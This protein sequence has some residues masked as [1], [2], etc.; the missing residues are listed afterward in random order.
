MLPSHHKQKTPSSV[1]SGSTQETPTDCSEG[2]LSDDEDGLFAS[3][4]H[5]GLDSD[6]SSVEEHVTGN[7]KTF[8]IKEEEL[9]PYV[10]EV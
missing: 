4:S 10:H 5:T 1:L 3:Y 6:G 8:F 7:F 9:R 2:D